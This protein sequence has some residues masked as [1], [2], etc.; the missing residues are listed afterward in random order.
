LADAQNL[1]QARAMG[2]TAGLEQ[3]A[4]RAQLGQAKNLAQA[5]L[6]QQAAAFG[7]QTDMQAALA[8][9]AQEQQAKQFQVGA[10]MD[11]ERL[12]EQLKQSGTLGYIDAATRL[13]A[14][15]DQATLD[16]F[17]ALLGRG[18]GQSLQ[19]GQGV[20][21]QANYGLQSGPQYLNP[22]AGLGFIS[23][24]AAND[25]NIAAAQAA[26][27]GS[28]MSGLMGGLGAIGGGLLGNANLF[29]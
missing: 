26:A 13:A 28:V 9:Q 20:L 21:G 22:E 15:E 10:Q 17:Q 5:E 27:S 16:P 8:N 29:K 11:A 2:L 12:N 6:D 3:D 14:L 1:Q 4:L 7:A 25:A 23:Q 19:A 18:G 24:M